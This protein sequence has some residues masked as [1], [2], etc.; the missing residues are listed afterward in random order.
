MRSIV[1]IGN[2]DYAVNW[3]FQQDGTL[4]VEADLTGIILAKGTE[5]TDIETVIYPK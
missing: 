3:V 1:T 4:K 2:Y 5:A